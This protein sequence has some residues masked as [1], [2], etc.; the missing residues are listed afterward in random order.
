MTANRDGQPVAVHHETEGAVMASKVNTP[1]GVYEVDDDEKA[2][3]E[4]QGL[5]LADAPKKTTEK[6]GDS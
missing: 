6:K 4:G 2:V 5:V 3:L 1:F